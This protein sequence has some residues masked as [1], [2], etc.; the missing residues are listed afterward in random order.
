[1][2]MIII[3]IESD[4]EKSIPPSSPFV[5]LYVTVYYENDL[6]IQKKYTLSV[7]KVK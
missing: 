7:E 2:M 3:I 5:L 4:F 6:M 1:M